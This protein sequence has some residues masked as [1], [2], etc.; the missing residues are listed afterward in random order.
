MLDGTAPHEIERLFFGHCRME[1]AWS[2]FD[3]A[4]DVTETHAQKMAAVTA[5]ERRSAAISDAPRQL[6]VR[7]SL[8]RQSVGVQFAEAF[9][10][11]SPLLVDS[12]LVFGKARFG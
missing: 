10:A 7:G 12:P 5:Y 8:R 3:F 4:V 1:P 9:K 2:V 11:R 6:T